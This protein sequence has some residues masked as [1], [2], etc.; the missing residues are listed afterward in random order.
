M[1]R[2]EGALLNEFRKG[3]AMQRSTETT[4][5]EGPTHCRGPKVGVQ[6]LNEPGEEL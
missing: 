3:R 1:G 4:W 6:E 2:P 5:A